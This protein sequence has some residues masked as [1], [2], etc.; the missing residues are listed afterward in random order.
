MPDPSLEVEDL[1]HSQP[2]LKVDGAVGDGQSLLASN[3]AE[4]HAA[5]VFARARSDDW[6][7]QGFMRLTMNVNI[8]AYK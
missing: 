2:K 3:P 5:R 8:C 1:T 7:G 4:L 6:P